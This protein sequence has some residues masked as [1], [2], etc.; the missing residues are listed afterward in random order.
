MKLSFWSYFPL[1]WC[2]P[3]SKI[4]FTFPWTFWT[5]SAS[6]LLPFCS[7]CLS[8]MLMPS[9]HVSPW[10]L[11]LIIM[12]HISPALCFIVFE[13]L[14]THYLVLMFTSTLWEGTIPDFLRSR[15]PK[16]LSDMLKSTWQIV[17]RTSR[18]SPLDHI[19]PWSLSFSPSLSWCRSLGH[20]LFTPQ[21]HTII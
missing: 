9:A 11:W 1:H 5:C 21:T 13:V 6:C 4:L 19:C 16:G 18:V 14:L 7:L 2:H 12:T 15:Y 8:F 3:V 17:I 20:S 10:T